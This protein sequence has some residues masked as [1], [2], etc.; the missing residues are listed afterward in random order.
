MSTVIDTHIHPALF[1]PICAD[2]ERFAFRCEE[3]NYHLMS[4]VDL[5]L[6]KKQL[7]LAEIRS[8]FLLGEDCSFEKG[9][10][11]ISNDELAKLVALEPGLFIGFASVDP[12][13]EDAAEELRRAF[14]ELGLAG[15]TL[16]TAK[17]R[18]YPWDQR[19]FR[20]CEICREYGKPVVLHSGFC[21]E[22][23]A[24]SRYA[25]P[26]DFEELIAAFPEINFCLTHVGWP[27]VQETAALLIKYPNAYANTALMNFDGPVQLYHKVFKEDMGE[28]WVEH[29]LADKLMFGSD[30]PRIRPV[31]AKRGLEALGLRPDVME[32]I[33][34]RNALR[35]L[36]REE[37][38]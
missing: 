37:K 29:N 5:P 32:K 1:A 18:L 19:I 13:R 14:T 8:V 10:S 15:L 7:G 25:R 27:W 6:L 35:F 21:L 11:A 22:K 38:L 36:G 2:R 30:S 4:P 23:D 12:R 28:Y 16:N 9:E 17:C 33:C 20:L 34:W 24:F 26:A 3:M 31:R